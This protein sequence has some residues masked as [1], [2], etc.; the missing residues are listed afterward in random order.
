MPRRIGGDNS[1]A[2]L[3]AWLIDGERALLADVL[4]PIPF[5]HGKEIPVEER[6]GPPDLDNISEDDALAW[7]LSS[8]LRDLVAGRAYRLQRRDLPDLHPAARAGA[9]GDA[10]ILTANNE[11]VEEL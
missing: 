9:L 1:G 10:L 5:R 3:R 2:E 11:L 4:T 7:I 8:G 6:V